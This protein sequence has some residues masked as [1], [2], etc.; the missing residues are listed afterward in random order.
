[1]I[2]PAPGFWPIFGPSGTTAVLEIMNSGFWE[3]YLRLEEVMKIIL[4]IC[5][6][7]GFRPNLAPRPVPTGRARK[8]VQNA[9]K[10]SPANQF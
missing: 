6:L 7:A 2:N 3:P 10:I 8:M 4:F 1:M 5:F 9:P